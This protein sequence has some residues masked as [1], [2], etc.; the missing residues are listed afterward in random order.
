MAPDILLRTIQIAIEETRCRHIGYSFRLA[1]RVLL[2]APS[3]RE[4]NT[5][6]GL[7]YT[8]RGIA[9]WVHP[10]TYRFDDPSHHERT[11]LPRSI[12]Y[13]GHLAPPLSESLI[14]DRVVLPSPIKLC[15]HYMGA[16]VGVGV[17][18]GGRGGGTGGCYKSTACYILYVAE[19]G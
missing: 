15:G 18:G 10:M 7:C 14:H 2:Y 13:H 4:D 16:G 6:H 9:Q 3:H 1:V 8:S 12:T 17:G 5:Y 19:G 11:L